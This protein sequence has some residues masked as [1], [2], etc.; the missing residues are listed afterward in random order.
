MEPTYGNLS[1]CLIQALSHATT[2]GFSVTDN[3]AWVGGVNRKAMPGTEAT[4]SVTQR[5][6]SKLLLSCR[7]KK[8]I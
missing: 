3:V 7:L 6:C 8:Y 2:Q 4:R 1:T 5:D